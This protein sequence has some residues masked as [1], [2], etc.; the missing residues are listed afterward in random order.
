MIRKRVSKR[1]T[2]KIL[3]ALAGVS[4]FP[5]MAPPVVFARCRVAQV[6]LCLT[7]IS[8]ETIWTAAAQAVY[9]V[10]RPKE[11]SVGGNKGS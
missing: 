4:P 6:Y 1:V 10:N 8:S 3:R 9:R 2:C 5:A 7:V 11:D